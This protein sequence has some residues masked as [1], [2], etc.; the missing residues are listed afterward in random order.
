MRATR[1]L[2]LRLVAVI[3]LPTTASGCWSIIAEQSTLVLPFRGDVE[4]PPKEAV[5]L[6]ST[7]GGGRC[8]PRRLVSVDEGPN[9]TVIVSEEGISTTRCEYLATYEQDYDLGNSFCLGS[10]RPLLA[11]HARIAPV[12]RGA[13]QEAWSA[14]ASV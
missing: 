6:G 11:G 12:V 13:W 9:R 7:D 3:V 2:C 8:H 5:P 4:C 10:G 14:P 1:R